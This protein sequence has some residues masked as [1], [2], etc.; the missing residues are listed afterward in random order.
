MSTK[1]RLDTHPHTHTQ[2]LVCT[3][4]IKVNWD[5]STPEKQTT[6][7]RSGKKT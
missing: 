5:N 6:Q 7:A 4:N 3:N 1:K 2:I